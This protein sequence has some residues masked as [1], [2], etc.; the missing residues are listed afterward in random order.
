MRRRPNPISRPEARIAELRTEAHELYKLRQSTMLT[1]NQ[2]DRIN[3]RLSE[4]ANEI[5]AIQNAMC[6]A[7]T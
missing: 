3:T 1:P 5:E 2:L 7:T 4:I 6:G